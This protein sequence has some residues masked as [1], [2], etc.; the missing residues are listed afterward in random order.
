LAH[1]TA[2]TQVQRLYRFTTNGII[3]EIDSKTT[4]FLLKSRQKLHFLQALNFSGQTAEVLRRFTL[5]A[6]KII[7]IERELEPPFW[8]KILDVCTHSTAGG[9]ALVGQQ[10]WANPYALNPLSTYH[11]YSPQI[12][13]W[14]QFHFLYCI[15]HIELIY[16]AV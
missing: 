13:V 1:T 14:D 4:K 9:K 10:K 7:W 6:A 2:V 12:S 3:A 11:G 15:N 8:R 16:F 5:T